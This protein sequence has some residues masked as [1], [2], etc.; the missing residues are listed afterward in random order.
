MTGE[1]ADDLLAKVMGEIDDEVRRRRASGDF[2]PSFER[3]L[4]QLFSRF[5]PVGVHDAHFNETLKLADRSAYVDISVPTASNKPG[6]G[7]LKRVL[8]TLMAWYL[9]YVVQQITHFTSATMRVL[10]MVD[11]RLAEVEAEVEASRPAHLADHDLLAVVADPSAWAEE[12]CSRLAGVKGRVLHAE[13]GDGTLIRAL[14]REGLDVY[15]VDPRAELLDSAAEASLDVRCEDALEHLRSVADLGLRG[16]VLSGCVDY[17]PV[18]FKREVARLAGEKLAA[19]G[20]VVIVATSPNQW[21]NQAPAVQADLA[22]GRPF[23]P[24]TWSHLLG[25]AGFEALETTWGPA[26]K[27][28]EPLKGSDTA[29]ATMNANLERLNEALFGPASYMVSGVRA[30]GGASAES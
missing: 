11:E 4:D 16:L 26:E 5:T 12:V 8:R 2:P 19:G 7:R 21:A 10:H 20:V 9:N 27:G 6:V 3:R 24:Q 1:A 30:S 23:N 15:G 17:L 22:P 14:A 13:C 29:A 28:L 18:R 25:A